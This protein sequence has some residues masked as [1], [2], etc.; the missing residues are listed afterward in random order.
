MEFI[1]RLFGRNDVETVESS[2]NLTAQPVERQDGVAKAADEPAAAADDAEKTPGDA[3]E[4]TPVPPEQADGIGDGTTRRLPL[5]KVIASKNDHLVFGQSTDVGMVRTNNQDAMMALH[6]T[7]QSVENRPEFGL[8]IVADGMGGHHDG[9]K[10]SAI[11]TRTVSAY[12][13]SRIFMPML[14][15]QDDDADR[16][17]ITEA[18]VEAI[19]KANNEVLDKVPDG[20]TTIT[21]VAIVG[22]LAYFAHVGDSRAYLVT[23]EDAEQITRDH[24]LVRR[25]V[26][27]GQI[28]EDEVETHPNKNVLYRAL[29]QSETLEVDALTR[30]IP[31]GARLL[32]CSDGLWSMIDE[33]LIFQIVREHVDPQEASDKLV[34]MANSLGGNDNITALV[35]RL[36]S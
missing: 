27:L 9:E 17:T 22:D 3:E 5:E 25:L 36:P 8:F 23:K 11:V 1:R 13:T 24:S 19:Q 15:N 2:S 16:P 6:V 35:L 34:A 7:G 30:R 14:T 4:A 28:E 20:G 18:L 12:V 29:G 32:L 10:A 21:V 33:Q 26:E 31:P